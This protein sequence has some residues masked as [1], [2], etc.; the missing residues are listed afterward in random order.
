M[1]QG[2]RIA[3]LALASVLFAAAGASL[4]VTAGCKGNPSGLSERQAER[5]MGYIPKTD[6]VHREPIRID[7][8]CELNET[9]VDPAEDS[10]EWVIQDMLYAASSP[11]DS[12]E[13]FQRFYGHFASEAESWVRQQH[14]PRGRQ[15]VDKY[16]ERDR[17]EGIVF[18]ICERRREANNRSRISIKSNDPEKSNPPITLEQTDDGWK[19]VFYTP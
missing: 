9:V 12:E 5:G 13:M 10:P 16:L 15:H 4:T 8:R 3:P 6:D 14:W 2:I 18:T 17:G 11:E 1:R 19:V 7:P